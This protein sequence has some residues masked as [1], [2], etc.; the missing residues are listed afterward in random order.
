MLGNLFLLLS[1]WL[2]LKFTGNHLKVL[3]LFPDRQR[4][5][6]F[7]TGFF[8]TAIL[9]TVYFLG[10]IQ[11]LDAEIQINKEYSFLSFLKGTLWTLQ[12]VLYEELLFRGAP[13]FLLMKYI[14]R[15]KGMILSATIF[16]IYHWFTYNVFGDLTQ[17]IFT[18]VITGV[19]GL[20]FAY[21]YHK[22][23]SLY[24]PIGLHLGWNFVTIV[25]FSQGVFTEDQLLSAYTE[26]EVGFFGSIV[27]LLY[28]VVIFPA[29]SLLSIRF[30]IRKDRDKIHDRSTKG[31]NIIQQQEISV[32]EKLPD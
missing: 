3:G 2:V 22:T 29:I 32:E 28:Q 21:A 12:S 23:R 26:N 25:L 9:A 20:V 27:S 19:G 7:V 10:L 18:F 16:G 1:S 5:L 6:Q 14:G 24:F 31:S 8:L 4:A 17:M 15:L 13:L 11:A 30:L